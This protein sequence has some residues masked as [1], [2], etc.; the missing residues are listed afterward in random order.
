[1]K[2][3]NHFDRNAEVI[4]YTGDCL[5]FL[6]Q[7]PSEFVQLI[8]TSPPY[9]IGK[10]YEKRMVLNDYV[11]QQKEVIE[12][13]VRVLKDT[14]SICWQVGNYV[15]NGEIIPL[16]IL[17][18]PVF[19]SLGLK[20]RNRIIWHFGHG[21]HASKR[22]SGRYE[23]ILWFT[24]T[25]N[26]TLNLDAV[27]V[28]QKYPNK[29]HF[30]G[31]NKGKLSGN[32]LGKNPSDIWEIPNVKSNHV[33]K[34]NHP[35]Q[36][37]IELIERLVLSMTDESDWVLDPFIGVGSTAIAALM[38]KRKAMGAE[39]KPEYISVAKERIHLAERGELRIRPMERPVYMPD[40][41]TKNIPP[42][43]IDLN[44]NHQQRSL[45]NL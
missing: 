36:F 45:F 39:I 5:D 2:I 26:Y 22:F 3:I 30:K 12:R 7:I 9:N 43:V 32:P 23:V 4:L 37:P 15:N 14:G 20:L 41:K 10:E 29:R 34:T 38:H 16:D 11:S 18:Y 17:L 44:S 25:D 42:R 27:R 28:S 8:V 21:L 33:E 24:R 31:P 6:S 13:C 1:M 35:C 19:S 40:S